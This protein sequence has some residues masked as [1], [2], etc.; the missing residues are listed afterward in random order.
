MWFVSNFLSYVIA[1]DAESLFSCSPV[2][3]LKGVLRPKSSDSLF[4]GARDERQENNF[5]YLLYQDKVKYPFMF[6]V[7]IVVSFKGVILSEI[8]NITA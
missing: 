2:F 8:E 6:H 3:V 1:A 4:I 7:V 5:I